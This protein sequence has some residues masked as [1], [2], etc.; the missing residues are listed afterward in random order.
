MTSVPLS[1]STF[2]MTRYCQIALQRSLHALTV[3][4]MSSS[5]SVSSPTLDVVRLF[6][7][8][9]WM[10]VKRDSPPSPLHR[11]H[12]FEF[13]FHALLSTLGTCHTRAV[14]C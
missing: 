10:A 13:L 3:V 1:I 5:C 8:V 2:N 4:E 7:L 14:V 6:T 11:H 12:L 9:R